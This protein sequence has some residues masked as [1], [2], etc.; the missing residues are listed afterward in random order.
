MSHYQHRK[1]TITDNALAALLHDPLYHQRVERARKG[2]GS[3]RRKEKFVKRERGE[4]SDKQLCL[5]LA[6]CF[7][8]RTTALAGC[9]NQIFGVCCFSRS[10]I[11]V[12]STSSLEG[13]G[14]GFSTSFL[15]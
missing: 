11:S 13:L 10:R 15:V 4:A 6:F 2:K 12:S 5:S 9:H 7:N 14:A 3:F 8:R 1:G